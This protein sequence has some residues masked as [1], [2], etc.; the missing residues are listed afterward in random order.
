MAETKDM[1][2]VDDEKQ[3][4]EQ[5]DVS[6][7]E[8]FEGEVR[9]LS[10]KVNDTVTLHQPELCL[11]YTALHW[12][13]RSDG[14]PW[15]DVEIK[16][17]IGH[18]VLKLDEDMYQ[19]LDLTQVI[20]LLEREE[21]QYTRDVKLIA[22]RSKRLFVSWFQQQ[23]EKYLSMCR[24]DEKSVPSLWSLTTPQLMVYLFGRTKRL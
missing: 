9:D 19:S 7:G 24:K 20:K 17:I 8:A 5:E 1:E 12:D 16:Q 15:N 6:E 21:D 3:E 23:H 4:E 22:E 14:T 10:L 2:Q 13:C 11:I 18:A